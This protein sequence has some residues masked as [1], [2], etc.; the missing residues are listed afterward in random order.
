[1]HTFMHISNGPEKSTMK[2]KSTHGE[3]HEGPYFAYVRVSTDD[4]DVERQK[5]DILDYLNGGG[6]TVTWFED[7]MSGTIPPEQRD[8]LMRCIREAKKVRGTIIVADLDRFSRSMWQ[9]LKFFDTTV[10]TGKCRLV[11]VADPM[12]S[13]DGLMLQMRSMIAEAERDKISDRTK[14]KL[15]YIKQQIGFD[16]YYVT[17]AGNKITRLGPDENALIKAREEANKI[18]AE[19]ADKFAEHM[20]PL[21]THYIKE[22]LSYR[23]IAEQLNNRNEPTRRGGQWYASTVSNLVRRLGL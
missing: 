14:S 1:M 3:E 5:K 17:E 20:S 22:G 21:L 4:Q 7:Y 16:G 23:E 18:V 6:H 10:K 2:F 19:Q 13:E 9:T 11:V 12:I 8:G 15:D